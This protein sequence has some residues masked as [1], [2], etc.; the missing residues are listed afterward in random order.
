MRFPRWQLVARS[1][2]YIDPEGTA[3]YFRL[4]RRLDGALRLEPR[5]S[6]L[7][8]PHLCVLAR[9]LVHRRRLQ[10]R[11]TARRGI[12]TL[13]RAAGEYFPAG[14]Q[15]AAFCAF[16]DAD[17]TYVCA[18]P[19][20]R[21]KEIEADLGEVQGLLVGPEAP[22]ERDLLEAIERRHRLGAAADL[23]TRPARIV[24]PARVAFAGALILLAAVA[25]A[26]AALI[27]VTYPGS[28]RL[29]R[30]AA[31]AEERAGEAARQ[32]DSLLKMLAAQRAL[33]ELGRGQGVRALE[34]TSAI[35][36]SAPAGHAITSV[37]FKNGELKVTGSGGRAVEWLGSLGV[38]SDA[39][40]T[41]RLKQVDRFAAQFPLPKSAARGT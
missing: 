22:L 33:G 39:I 4:R 6:A 38:P 16:E 3:H 29:A 21:I 14:L 31:A 13:L 34:A 11:P 15:P 5:K 30:R 10:S 7:G 25:A 26:S 12:E 40:S 23:V 1:V 27:S 36:G 24:P 17:G 2:V 20:H 8:G 28:E 35:L 18:L 41:Y 32:Y 19:E 9:S 37:E